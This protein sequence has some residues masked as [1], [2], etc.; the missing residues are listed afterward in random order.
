M[1]DISDG[2]AADLNHICEES[3]CGAVLIAEEI[4]ISDAA[5]QLSGTSGRSPL[6]HAIGDGE[7]FELV[8]VVS[9]A[10]G[11]KLLAAPPVPGLRKIGA[12]VEAGLWIAEG[13]VRRPL[14][15]AGWVHDLGERPA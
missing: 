5:R 15:P 1:L 12:C 13:G 11:A 4:P 14:A 7:D 9:P 3:G 10:D 2:L 8:F 6:A